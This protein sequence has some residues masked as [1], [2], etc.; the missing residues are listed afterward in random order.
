MRDFVQNFVRDADGG[1]TCIAPATLQLDG[2]RI[3]V[4]PGT[5]FTPG[6]HFMNV[7]VAKLL[8]EAAGSPSARRQP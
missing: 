7:D 4:T 6:T 5:R 2:G 3:Q 1:W 8:E